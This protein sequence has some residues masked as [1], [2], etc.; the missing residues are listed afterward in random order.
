MKAFLQTMLRRSWLPV[1]AVLLVAVC[2]VVAVRIVNAVDYQNQYTDFFPFWLTGNL[3]TRG[4]SPYDTLQWTMGYA[5][6]NVGVMLDQSFLYPL[7]LSLFFTPFG[8]LPLRTAQIL[9]VTLT[10]IVIVW[11]LVVLLTVEG[12]PNAKYL[13]LPSLVGIVFFRPAILTLSSGHISGLLLLFL[14][15]SL[16]LLERKKPFWGGF[17]LAFLAL[18]PN[19]G[20]PLILLL[21]IWLF[22]RKQFTS[23]LGLLAGG[24]T[25][26]AIGFVQDPHWILEYWQIGNTKLAETFGGSPT[27]WGLAALVCRNQMRCTLPIGGAATLLVLAGFVWLVFKARIT[28]PLM[29]FAI[30][31][32]LTLLITPYTWT[33]DQL[34]LLIPITTITLAIGKSKRGFLPA[35][36]LFLAID[37]LTIILLIFDTILDVEILNALIPLLVL[38]LVALYLNVVDPPTPH[39]APLGDG[40]LHSNQ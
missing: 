1:V 12:S 24:V 13:F 34:L 26:M 29:A 16:L 11:S 22:S 7:P 23:L 21:S 20:G 35:A 27:F 28:R 5:Q 31:V 30:V 33:Y 17:L 3:V 40:D 19:I 37:S 10:Q 6:N 38:G 9:W 39:P 25:L 14:T 8:I 2:Y 18:K 4:Q 36:F 32:T 15:A